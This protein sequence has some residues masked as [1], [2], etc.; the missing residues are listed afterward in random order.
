MPINLDA[1]LARI[2]YTGP[3]TPDLAVLREVC[4]LHPMALTFN[5]V[6]PWL[7]LPVRL[8]LETLEAKLVG[9]GRG[10]YCYEQ[11]TLLMAAL[12]E[13]GFALRGLSARVVYSTP[14]GGGRHP[15]NHMLMLVELAEGAF[16]ADAGFG[17]LTL[18]APLKLE[19][20]TIQQT[21]HERVRFG[22]VG[23]DYV[24]E[25]EAGDSWRAMY[26]FDMQEQIDAD[27]EMANWFTSTYP[28]SAF[29]QR[30]IAARPIAGGRLA[31][32]D[33][34]LSIHRTGGPS[35][36]RTITNAADLRRLLE[37]DLEITLPDH[38]ELGERLNRVVAAV[39]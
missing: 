6:Y 38:P 10:G 3:R 5:S 20:D 24:L 12:K 22:R 32:S 19:A 1:Y 14:P 21:P 31:L 25:A 8:D 11:N 9:E 37:V 36:R 2:G 4:R 28:G 33:A 18:T 13:L 27:Y 17:G 16:I 35:E 39:G 34:Q 26:Q 7:G 29:V 23:S 15:R 30:L